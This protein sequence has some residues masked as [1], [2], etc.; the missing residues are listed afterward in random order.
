[1]STWTWDFGS[2]AAGLQFAVAYSNETG[3]FTIKVLTGSLNVNAL[4]WSDGDS[5]GGEDTNNSINGFHRS[6]NMNGSNVVWNDDGTSTSFKQTWDGGIKLSDP[7][8]TGTP[9]D[10]YLTAGG[11][12]TLTI[13]AGSF[14]PNSFST[15]GVRATST[16]TP[17][18]G[19][20]WAD[21]EPSVTDRL[22]GELIQNWSFE[23]DVV[24]SDRLYDSFSSITGWVNELYELGGKIELVKAGAFNGPE[25][26]GQWLDTQASPG[27]I[28]I[29]QNLDVDT[30]ATAKLSVSVA[31]DDLFGGATA[32]DEKLI[33]NFNDIEVMTIQRSD[34]INA[35]IPSNTFHEFAVDVTG[36]AGLDHLEISSTAHSNFGFAVDWVSLKQFV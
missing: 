32:P 12:D 36:A 6:L 25:G 35:G 21:S 31:V 7:G 13:D 18:G 19:I 8:L 20:K 22:G 14:D 2:E 11:N 5:T 23:E 27:P 3:E 28:D 17:D 26:D 24:P 16:S 29:S 33:F 9:P 10:T 1:M 30:D 34:F 15:L 4:E